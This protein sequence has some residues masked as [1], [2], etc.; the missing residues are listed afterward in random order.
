[1]GGIQLFATIKSGLRFFQKKKLMR[2]TIIAEE[3][4]THK[5]LV[6]LGFSLNMLLDEG[7]SALATI[8]TVANLDM[9]TMVA[10]M[11]TCTLGGFIAVDVEDFG[12]T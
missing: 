5:V 4:L 7:V 12:M 10:L 2:I 8:S 11:N 9:M 3:V 6:G 1:M